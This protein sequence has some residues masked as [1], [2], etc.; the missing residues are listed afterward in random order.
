MELIL[1]GYN[2]LFQLVLITTIF[3]YGY[4]NKKQYSISNINYLFL[5]LLHFFCCIVS[6]FLSKESSDAFTYYTVV[7]NTSNW[8]SLFGFGAGFIKFIIYPLINYFK[9][10]FLSLFIIFSSFSFFGFLILNKLFSR[11]NGDDPMQIFKLNISTI[12]LF[13]PGFHLW[14][15]PMGKDSLIFYLT[16][17]V[18]Y[19]LIFYDNKKL[20]RLI[21]FLVLILFIRFYVII[22][23]L[24]GLALYHAVHLLSKL[25]HFL[26]FTSF[27][28]IS[29][30]TY[31]IAKVKFNFELFIFLEEKLSYI[32]VYATRKLE[33]GSYIDPK[34]HNLPQ[35]VF[36]Y[37][38]GP[39]IFT[40]Q[41]YMQKYVA[42]ENII[43]FIVI[44]KGLFTFSFNRV[45][46]S[47]IISVLFFYSLIFLII[48]AYYMYNLG[49]ANRQKYMIIPALLIVIFYSYHKSQTNQ[50]NEF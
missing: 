40:A 14:V 17:V 49:L 21:F 27:I 30:A 45:F 2:F 38:F 36:I 12:I 26:W 5:F 32:S 6:W 3:I 29:F 1:D 44:L 8:F 7:S 4:R 35:K 15:S 50:S 39:D 48:N 20:L 42:I 37:L 13:L 18:F 46:K 41:S 22:Y 9:L 11:L 10:N 47:K 16:M 34:T 19:R 31:Y 25:K 24:L 28:I 23:L 43:L 33:M